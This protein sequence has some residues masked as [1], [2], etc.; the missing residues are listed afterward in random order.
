MIA[1]LLATQI[2][3]VVV[4]PDRAQVTR[5]AQL[6]CTGTSG[7]VT[8][9]ALPPGAQSAR[10]ITSEGAVVSLDNS[11]EALNEGF[12]TATL[13][14]QL[15]VIEAQLNDLQS[16]RAR[17]DEATRLAGRLAEVA[18]AQL[19]T[20]MATDP[21]P[22]VKSW[23]SA[24][25]QTLQA[26]LVASQ[27]RSAT[28]PR[29]RELRRRQAELYQQRVRLGQ[30]ADRR[31]RKTRVRVSCAIGR[32]AQVELTY[33]VGAVSWQPAY[34]ARAG[35]KTVALS[36]FA[37]VR[38]A[39]GESWEGARLVLSTALP[40]SDATPPE[41]EPLRVFAAPREPP[42]KVLVRRDEVQRHAEAGA[43]SNAGAIGMNA[44]DQGL[45]VQLA[46]KGVADVAGDST[47]ARLFVGR[48]ELSAEFVLRTVP[49]QLPYVF[50]VAELVNSAPFPLLP[51]PV[52]L[53]RRGAYL[54][55]NPLER[56]PQGGK[57]HLSFG[58]EEGIK[59]KRIV[60]DEIKRDTGL[61]KNNQ[62]F[63]YSYR[64]EFESSAK[65][66]VEVT[67]QVPV[68]ELDDVQVEI[69][70]RTTPG[71]ERVPLDGILRWKLSLDAG[72][73]TQLDLAFHVDVPSSYQAA[74]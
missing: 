61:F 53:F 36:L 56:V 1:L 29:E 32:S 70:D 50:Q 28:L 31:E 54:G 49:R 57:F 45:S 14:A 15:R 4:Y 16:E 10:A 39:T 60:L 35:E 20:E 8:F 38:Q 13:D 5:V 47:P 66:L 64:Y 52:L 21:A 44:S 6:S 40:S 23:R 58:L 25:E 18:V 62:R 19:S 11:E 9:G 34:E 63:H 43:N 2:A 3:R 12:G 26:R 55:T 27:E 73:K 30:A 33:Q 24:F 68:S 67:E 37:T 51:G 48:A 65:V 22:D 7:E 42:R 46:V 74:F 69:E 59:V 72:E 71:Y 17:A 41:V